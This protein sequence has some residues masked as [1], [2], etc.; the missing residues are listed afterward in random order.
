MLLLGNEGFG[1]RQRAVGRFDLGLDDTIA[2][3]PNEMAFHRIQR[4]AQSVRAGPLLMLHE[5]EIHR[6]AGFLQKVCEP[7]NLDP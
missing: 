7:L 5:W 2:Q 6:P 3:A 4:V 1:I